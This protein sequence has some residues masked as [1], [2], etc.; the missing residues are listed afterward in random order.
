M[1][2]V[3][4]L[5]KNSIHADQYL[6]MTE[7][8]P[9]DL[10][11]PD[12]I[13]RIENEEVYGVGTLKTHVWFPSASSDY[14]PDPSEPFSQSSVA[15]EIL[16]HE[17]RQEYCEVANNPERGFHFHLGRPL[18]EILD[19]PEAW[20]ETIPEGAIESFAGTGNPIS[21]WEIGLV[22]LVFDTSCVAG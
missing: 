1:L 7:R 15:V 12:D 10:T 19:Y 13:E 21:L 14:A 8:A 18:T 22:G 20:L 5:L 4:V 16:R 6:L 3:H 11:I 9:R 2:T 17:I